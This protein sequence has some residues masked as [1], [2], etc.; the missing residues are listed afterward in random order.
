LQTV[1]IANPYQF[2]SLGRIYANNDYGGLGSHK[3]WAYCYLKN[4]FQ[5]LSVETQLALEDTNPFFWNANTLKVTCENSQK[6]LEACI[7]F[8]RA[9]GVLFV[10]ECKDYKELAFFS[11][12]HISNNTDPYLLEN[13][14]LLK[15]FFYFLYN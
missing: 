7:H 1:I 4:D 5:K 3:E 14:T 15:K 6:F 9:S 12:S 11:T 10:L 13:I 8:G 2:F